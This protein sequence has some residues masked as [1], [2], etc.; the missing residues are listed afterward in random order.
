MQGGF[1]KSIKRA[2]LGG[3]SLFISTFTASAAG[4]WVDVAPVLPGDI[5]ATKV[6]PAQALFISRSSWLCSEAT[7]ELDTQWGGFKNLFG[8][9]GG[10]LVRAH[11]SGQAVLAC[12]GALDTVV[13]GPGETVVVDSG[14]MVAYD[15]G[16][17]MNLRQAANGGGGR[18]GGLIKS[19]TSGE[20]LVFT[21][22]GPGSVLTQTR[23]P[24]A[25][26]GWLTDVLPFKPAGAD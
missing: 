1:L 21:F 12:Y 18:L 19:A 25:L 9:E 15:E 26:T 7:V 20:G 16:V 2:A 14:H 8:G 17:T 22:T 10:F 3:E 5:V 24:R 6:D 4:G 23:N 13:L 11:G